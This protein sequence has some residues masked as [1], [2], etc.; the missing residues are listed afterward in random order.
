MQQLCHVSHNLN[1]RAVAAREKMAIRFF[2]IMI[3]LGTFAFG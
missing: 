2:A 1:D 3:F